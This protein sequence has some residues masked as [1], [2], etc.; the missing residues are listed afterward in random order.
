MDEFHGGRDRTWKREIGSSQAK[1]RAKLR[2]A[3]G[4]RPE[5]QRRTRT[6]EEGRI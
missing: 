6:K 2:N 1:P 4:Q 5:K 3:N